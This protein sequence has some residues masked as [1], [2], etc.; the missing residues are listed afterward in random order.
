MHK[1]VAEQRELSPKKTQ[2]KEKK[3][4]KKKKKKQKQP[5]NHD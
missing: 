3:K 1:A 4:K 2:S 5:K